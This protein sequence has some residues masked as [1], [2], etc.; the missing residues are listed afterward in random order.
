V[1]SSAYFRRMFNREVHG[2]CDEAFGVR[3]VVQFA[4]LYNIGAGRDSDLRTQ[5]HTRETSRAVSRFLHHAFGVVNVSEHHNPRFRAQMEI[6]KLMA[7][8]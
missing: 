6:P 1:L 7:C 3:G 4:R 2:P 5:G 8:G